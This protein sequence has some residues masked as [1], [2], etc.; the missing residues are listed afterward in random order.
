MKL[1]IE[2]KEETKGLF[3]KKQ[4]YGLIVVVDLTA[5][6][7]ALIK[8]HDWGQISLGEAVCIGNFTQDVLLKFFVEK[9]GRNEWTAWFDT[10][11][12]LAHYKALVIDGL[13][14][15]K[16]RLQV[17]EGGIASGPQ[18]IEL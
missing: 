4:I 11:E 7:H 9:P 14:D 12:R 8:K 18:E 3:S 15:L 5:E 16:E 1:T 13:K 17:V 6:E 2:Q 10:V